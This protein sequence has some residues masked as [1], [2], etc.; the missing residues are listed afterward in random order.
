MISKPGSIALAGLAGLAGLAQAVP[1]EQHRQKGTNG[2]PA[3]NSSTFVL[4]EFQLYPE[5]AKFD[6]NRC[7]VY[8]GYVRILLQLLEQTLSPKEA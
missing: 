6:F 7:L 3:L 2:C 4:D 1:C 5:N 8:F